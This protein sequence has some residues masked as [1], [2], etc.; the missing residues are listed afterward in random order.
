LRGKYGNKF[1]LNTYTSAFTQRGTRAALF[2]N[3]VAG[4]T[5]GSLLKPPV[6]LELCAVADFVG[7]GSSSAGEG[8]V[9]FV[10]GTEENS[11]LYDCCKYPSRTVLL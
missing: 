1:V 10:A 3:S 2:I 8:G 11:A 6:L 7:C 5:T 4:L 9:L